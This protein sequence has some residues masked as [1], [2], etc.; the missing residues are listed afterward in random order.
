MKLTKKELA[1]TLAAL[2]KFQE[3]PS[4]GMEHFE[5]CDPLKR[6]EIDSLCERL[7]C[8]EIRQGK[9]GVEGPLLK[10]VVHIE[11]GIIQGIHTN[12][13]KAR[14]SVYDTDP[15]FSEVAKEKR[16]LKRAIKG[17]TEVRG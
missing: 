11:E 14:V 8:P 3:R 17:L 7:N 10:I 6:H 2:R 15:E 4:K 9:K 1:T 5:S 16:N 12:V 13:P